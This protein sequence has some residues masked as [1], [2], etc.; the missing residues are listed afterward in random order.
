MALMSSDSAAPTPLTRI[1]GRLEPFI[2]ARLRESAYTVLHGVDPRSLLTWNRLDLGLKLI[3]LGALETCGEYAVEVYE[4]DIRSQ[5]L[6]RFVEFGDERKSGLDRY[7]SDFLSIS[8]SIRRNGFDPQRTLIPVAADGS[9]LNGAHRVAAAVYA[10]EPVSVVLT[11]LPPIVCDYRYFLQRSV[12]SDL[13]Y[14]AAYTLLK[15]GENNYVAFL[16]P[17]GIE[18]LST[19]EPLVKRVVMKRTL[20]LSEVGAFN[21]LHELYGHT[22]WIGDAT[23]GYPG[24]K[25]KRFEC[26]PPQK[27]KRATVIAFQADSLLAVQ[28][29]KENVRS[30][31]G[32]G[33]SSVHVTDTK[34]EALGVAG[35][36]F[37][38]NG[39]HFLNHANP[40]RFGTVERVQA[41]I[42]V[43]RDVQMQR[44]DVLIDGSGTLE[45]YGVRRADDIDGFHDTRLAPPGAAPLGGD[46][47]HARDEQL[48]YHGTSRGHLMADHRYWFRY[49][50][51]KFVSLEQLAAMK[52]NRGE[53]KD[54][55]DL[56]LI[57]AYIRPRGRLPTLLMTFRYR[58]TYLAHRARPRAFELA[59]A[60]LLRLGLLE[61]ARAAYRR[62]FKKAPSMEP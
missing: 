3:T 29:V 60:V 12:P 57:D 46:V 19:T 20:T 25:Q 26:F 31:C 48:Q 17:S 49:A 52:R 42:P 28:A 24:L 23:S 1:V 18:H 47:L 2:A 51:A 7:L 43:L 44:D 33:F 58:L 61:T 54:H 6:G 8:S 10:Q 59:K 27:P 4:H 56:A 55:V 30:I 16:W 37:S 22:A 32:I 14:E 40:R 62:A 39:T 15:W 9:I 36:V 35:L 34:L 11:E 21:V 50:R 53:P 38:E 41:H 45:L 5:T 13:V